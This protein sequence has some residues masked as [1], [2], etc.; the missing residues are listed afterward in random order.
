M[1]HPVAPPAVPR[2]LSSG[3]A[4]ETLRRSPGTP[5]APCRAAPRPAA[6]T[7][8]PRMLHARHA[9]RP[10]SQ[11]SFGPRPAIRR[12]RPA[13]GDPARI[14]PR[15][16]IRRARRSHA[17]HASAGPARPP[18]R[19]R[20]RPLCRSGFGP[21]APLAVAVVPVDRRDVNS[22]HRGMAVLVL[23]DGVRVAR[24]F[25]HRDRSAVSLLGVATPTRDAPDVY[26]PS[27]REPNHR[28]DV[29]RRRRDLNR[30]NPQRHSF[31]HAAQI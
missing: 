22:G 15:P 31:P 9:C 2:N 10:A 19:L 24:L 3:M 13:P 21:A 4:G 7:H 5:I 12:I 29:G 18:G 20:R 17:R 14:S 11:M 28:R 8:P 23:V 25:V 26:W 27:H 1:S 6:V 16:T 30:S